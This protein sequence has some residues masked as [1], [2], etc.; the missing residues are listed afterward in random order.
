MIGTREQTVV[1]SDEVTVDE[2]DDL[3]GVA[4]MSRRGGQIIIDR[5]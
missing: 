4:G 5:Q 1:D 3:D 2:V